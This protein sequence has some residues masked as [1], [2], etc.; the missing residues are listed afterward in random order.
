MVASDVAVSNQQ[1]N[2]LIVDN[3]KANK[4]FCLYA[5]MHMNDALNAAA[6]KIAVPILNKSN[7]SKI[8]LPL[9]PLPEQRRIA[10]V[11]SAVQRAIEQQ[12]ELI[13]RTTELKKAL[14]HKLFTEG[15]RGEP[16]KETEIGPVPESW[17]VVRLGDYC[18]VMSSST[19]F[20]QINNLDMGNTLSNRV[21]ALK[22]SDM[23]LEGNER[24]INHSK[25]EFYP[26]PK[27]FEM[28]NKTVPQNAIIFPK[29]GAAIATN[30]KRLLGQP[31]ILDP[32]LIAVV[33]VMDFFVEFLFCHFEQIDLKIFTEPG[34]LPQL[35]KKNLEPAM[36]P[37]PEME[38]QL[39]ITQ[40]VEH[41]NDKIFQAVVHFHVL[42]DLFHTLLH[43]LMAAE[44]RV[45]EV[46]LSELRAIGIA[47]D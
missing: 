36:L 41:V 30:K 44:I 33:P 3:H 9:P 6:Q 13:A 25:I 2:A 15:T 17:D 21:L 22:V 19:P 27:T 46:D 42:Q 34:C 32:N 39:E 23:N 47:V 11:L 7:F 18:K 8:I 40:M 20:K 45:D 10:A 37:K 24:I 38:E 28:S 14:M 26:D 29:R 1:I 5:I 16:Q 43:Q 12:E 35:N 31:A 4:W